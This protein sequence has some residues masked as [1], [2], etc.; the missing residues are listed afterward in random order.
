MHACKAHV[1]S[2]VSRV[3]KTLRTRERALRHP[4]LHLRPFIALKEN[5]EDGFPK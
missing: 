1:Q 4:G 3:K 2:L 5:Y